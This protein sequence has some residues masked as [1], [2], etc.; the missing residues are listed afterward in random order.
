MEW[1]NMQAQRAELLQFIRIILP[2]I[3][4]VLN[5]NLTFSQQSQ[6]QWAGTAEYQFNNYHD[7]YFTGKET[8]GPPD[9]FPPGILNRRA[10]RL[11]SDRSFGTL[12]VAYHQPQQ[13]QHVIIV[14]NYNPG[15]LIQVK[16]KD[17]EGKYHLVYQKS[18]EKI[19]RDFR[20]L[21]I[22]MP[23]TTYKVSSIELNI[24][25]ISAP[26]LYQIDAVGILDSEGMEVIHSELRGANF[27]IEQE[28]TFS[29]RKELLSEQ[30]NSKYTEVKPLVSHDG[31]TLYFSRLF[32]PENTYGTRDPQDIYFSKYLNGQWSRAYNIGSPLN[33]DLANGI[34]S[35]SPDGNTILVINGYEAS[36]KVSPGV[37]MSTRSTSG[38]SDPVKI[39]IEDFVNKSPYQDFYISSDQQ[40]LIMA[41]ENRDGEG[42]QDLF[43]S[44]KIGPNQYSKPRNMGA[45]INTSYAEFS[46][47]LSLD[48]RNLYFASDG[49]GGY[50]Q[51]DIFKTTRL[52]DTWQNW[53]KPQNMGAAVN[54][55]S[56]DAYFSITSGGDY[57]YFV[58]SEGSRNEMENIFRIPLWRDTESHPTER[59][60]TFTGKVEDAKTGKSINSDISLQNVDNQYTYLSTSDKS[61][62][63]F[64]LYVPSGK[65]HN[66]QVKAPGYI[67]YE[68]K[69]D[70]EDI[71]PGEKAVKIVQLMPIEVGQVVQLKDLFFEQGKANLLNQSLPTLDRLLQLMMEN[72]SLEIE[73]SG[74]TDRVG[75]RTANMDLSFDRVERIKEYLTQNGIE[76]ERIKTIGHGGRYPI[77]PSDSEENRAKN[78]RVEVKV[79]EINVLN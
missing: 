21:V 9:A 77:S 1:I 59:F 50:G 27:N 58:S 70:L 56:W 39:E 3:L 57:A 5:Y 40:Y 23:K 76:A 11:E 10:F 42:D 2:I 54:T 33:D 79:L 34:C 65:S 8:L 69:V 35:I 28:I 17:T 41:I 20:T 74:H 71:Q 73:L 31:S 43:I 12:V 46:P 61:S 75:G 36:G 7:E 24:N 30:I 55:S 25:C 22:S 26:G 44:E 53:S 48:G 72:P 68:E 66:I 52:D 64:S 37:S 15:R 49:H 51:S 60:I 13:I 16:L 45:M 4:L 14:E 32:S 19:R 38:W 6:I 63:E 18:P 47:F 67:T 29:E 78:R 62:G